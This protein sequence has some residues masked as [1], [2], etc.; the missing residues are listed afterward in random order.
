MLA[1]LEVPR[2][3]RSWLPSGGSR[4]SSPWR[5]WSRPARASVADAAEGSRG[6]E[7][8]DG[9]VRGAGPRAPDG[10]RKGNDH[11]EVVLKGVLSWGDLASSW[12]RGRRWKRPRHG[13]KG[14]PNSARAP[15]DTASWSLRARSRCEG[16]GRCL[17]LATESMAVL[18]QRKHCAG[19]PPCTSF[20]VMGGAGGHPGRIWPR[21]CRASWGLFLQIWGH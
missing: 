6:S 12:P 11:Q 8:E 7:G 13:R 15:H 14:R 21:F 17:G 19:L 1:A 2:P 3:N 20:P 4:V 10:S 5:S 18:C 16:S 9:R